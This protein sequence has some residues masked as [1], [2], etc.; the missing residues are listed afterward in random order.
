M[1]VSGRCDQRLHEF[2]DGISR[3][4]NR[5]LVLHIFLW[6]VFLF[7]KKNSSLYGLGIQ[8]VAAS[9]YKIKIIP[10][11][12]EGAISA[13]VDNLIFER[14]SIL[15]Y[16]NYIGTLSRNLLCNVD[17]LSKITKINSIT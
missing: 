15:S 7:S 14:A 13:R 10:I 3:K 9:I 5:N 11:L 2:G 12:E 16:S 17:A 6:V 4:C 1:N 8:C